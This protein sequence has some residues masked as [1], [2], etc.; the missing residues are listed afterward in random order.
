M[1]I[2]QTSGRSYPNVDGGALN[3]ADAEN[4]GVEGLSSRSHLEASKTLL[5]IRAESGNILLMVWAQA[6]F[7]GESELVNKYVSLDS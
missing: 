1:A 3:D 5:T 7:S 4:L 6:R 2:N